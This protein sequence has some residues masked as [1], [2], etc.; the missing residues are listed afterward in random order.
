MARKEIHPYRL[1]ESTLNL[2]LSCERKFE[3][4]RLMLQVELYSEEHP[5][6]IRGKAFGVGVQV[7]LLTGDIDLAIFK[8]WLEYWPEVENAPYVCM[9]RTLNNIWNCKE[10]LDKIR[11]R[12]EVAVFEGKPAAE[13]SF[14]LDIDDKW[15]YVGYIDLVLWDKEE[16][17]YVVL[18]IK[19]T[20]Y[21][22]AD[23]S[24][25]YKN[26]GQALGYSIVLDKVTGEH[27]S[28]YGVLYLV[29]RDKSS[30]T[31][32]VPEVYQFQFT[33]TLIDRY[34][35]FI[36]LGL[37]V[38]RINRMMEIGIFP[39]RGKACVSFNKVCQHYGTCSIR[40]ADVRR[41]PFEDTTQ[42]QFH[43]KLQEIVEDH[44]HRLERLEHAE[45]SK[46]TKTENSLV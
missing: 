5:A 41:K 42:Y 4:E 11:R 16:Q 44:L 46:A 3:L 19:T 37:D 38:E 24:P 43:Y 35:W 25:V 23:L 18:E 30:A 32:W 1:S 10:Q 27:Q 29:C 45:H 36:S 17:I 34:N 7:Y 15:F 40:S 33:K 2:L 31:D 9:T 39:M 21:K 22:L 26:S 13:M 20:G 8:A 6:M 12:Y 28:K 14:R